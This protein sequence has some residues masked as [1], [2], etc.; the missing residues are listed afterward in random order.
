MLQSPAPQKEKAVKKEGKQPVVSLVL[1]FIREKIDN[2]KKEMRV[3]YKNPPPTLTKRELFF[4][5][6][7][8]R[9]NAIKCQ[10]NL[11]LIKLGGWLFYGIPFKD[12]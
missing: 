3:D 9:I 8:A 2:F 10:V 5:R 7:K 11:W 4:C 1:I 12:K 6:V